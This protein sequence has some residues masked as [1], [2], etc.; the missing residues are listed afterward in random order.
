MKFEIR[1][2]MYIDVTLYLLYAY[3]WNQYVHSVNY[4]VINYTI[5]VKCS[6]TE[7]WNLLIYLYKFLDLFVRILSRA[8]AYVCASLW[9]GK[10]RGK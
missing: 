5:S 7:Y 1:L 2:K 10:T 9:P 4:V 3:T 6:C 8:I